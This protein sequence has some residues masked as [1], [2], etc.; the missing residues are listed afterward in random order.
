MTFEEYD[1]KVRKL[2]YTSTFDSHVQ[3]V[4]SNVPTNAVFHDGLDKMESELN[5]YK[6]YVGS[7]FMSST[8]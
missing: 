4:M 3:F 6:K 8:E 2:L 1:K 5:Q 7:N